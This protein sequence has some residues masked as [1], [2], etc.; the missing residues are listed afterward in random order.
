MTVPTP[1]LILNKDDLLNNEIATRVL[2]AKILSQQR[3]NSCQ[4]ISKRPFGETKKYSYQLREYQD[5][6]ALQ[7]I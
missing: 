4:Q 1:K 5:F 2:N 3:H 7:N 6:K